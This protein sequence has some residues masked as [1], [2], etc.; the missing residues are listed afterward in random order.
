[1]VA[2]TSKIPVEEITMS[3][4]RARAARKNHDA[5]PEVVRPEFNQAE[6]AI[7]SM[8]RQNAEQARRIAVLEAAVAERDAFLAANSTLLGL[9]VQ[10]IPVQPAPEPVHE[11]P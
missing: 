8:A 3:Q 11:E 5:R 2:P 4:P 6:H 7:A 1:M 10:S 9:N